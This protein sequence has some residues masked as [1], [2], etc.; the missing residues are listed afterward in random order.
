M[1]HLR[2]PTGNLMVDA[3]KALPM[4]VIA[5]DGKPRNQQLVPELMDLGYHPTLIPAVSG[6]ELNP[7]DIR[8]MVD[9]AAVRT[10]LMRDL[11]PGEMGCALSHRECYLRAWASGAEWTVILEDDAHPSPWFDSLP[12]ILSELKSPSP[13]VLT[14][15]SLPSL[16]LRRGSRRRITTQG[17]SRGEAVVARYFQPPQLT[18]GYA[19]NRSALRLALA[20]SRLRG[21][22]DWPPWAY[23]CEFWGAFPWLVDESTQASTIGRR[24]PVEPPSDGSFAANPGRFVGTR[25]GFMSPR[26]IQTWSSLLGGRGNY[27]K[28]VAIPRLESI[29]RRPLQRKLGPEPDAPNV[30]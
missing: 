4:M 2:A 16:P 27:A 12:A 23:F 1:S 21:V 8:A 17:R 3:L 9:L 25:I 29:G 19:I 28:C 18:L 24:G 20:E 11:L 26:E 22:A 6:S 7:D 5:M 15:R 30:R 10:H 13:R 14:F